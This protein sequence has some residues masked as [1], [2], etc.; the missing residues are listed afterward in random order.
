MLPFEFLYLSARRALH[1]GPNLMRIGTAMLVIVTSNPTMVNIQPIPTPWI[2]GSIAT[3]AAALYIQILDIESQ[4][5]KSI[6]LPKEASCQV[7]WGCDGSTFSGKQVHD[8]R[9]CT[10][11][12][13]RSTHAH[14][15]NISIQIRLREKSETPYLEIAK[16][17]PPAM[18]HCSAWPTHKQ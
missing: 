4:F 8:K 18:E 15:E 6:N 17:M 2:P 16:S 3:E 14:Y 13:R 9:L 12:Q 7:V 1:F 11:S 10:N 5:L